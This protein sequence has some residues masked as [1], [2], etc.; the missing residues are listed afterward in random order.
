MAK[1]IT[2]ILTALILAGT[3]NVPIVYAVDYGISNPPPQYGTNDPGVQLNRTREYM[4][5]Q[6]VARQ[7]A[8]DRAKQRAE[9]EGCGQ[10]QQQASE[11]AV[12]FVLNDVKID[13]SEVLAET[14]IKEITGK[15]IGQEVTLQSLYDIV[16]NINELYS[17]KG[18]LT[19][20][21]ICRRKPLKTAWWKL[22]LLKAKPATCISAAMKAPMTVIL[23][24]ASGLT[25]A[26]S[27][28]ST[29]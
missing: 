17:E 7:I 1:Q 18:Y 28:I 19:C 4:E 3:I 6:R 29:S 10:E 21:L 11:N 26:A 23:P 25:A 22:K 14:E 8:E 9:V 12:K 15:Y 16:N 27:A 5:R 20:G 13:K 2:K 24:G